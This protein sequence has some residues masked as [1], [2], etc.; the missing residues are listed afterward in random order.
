MDTSLKETVLSNNTNGLKLDL[1]HNTLYYTTFY[2]TSKKKEE[3]ARLTLSMRYRTIPFHS[4]VNTSGA[5]YTLPGD[6]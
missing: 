3:N 5:P 6:S 2:D 1:V 4:P